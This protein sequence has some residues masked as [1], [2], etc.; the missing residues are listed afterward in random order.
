MDEVQTM[1]DLMLQFNN[2]Y[3]AWLTQNIK[4]AFGYH[5]MSIFFSYILADKHTYQNG[6]YS[7]D[8][9]NNSPQI[10]MLLYL[11]SISFYHN[12]IFLCG[13]WL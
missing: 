4:Q 9:R 2:L 8:N 7:D 1:A 6:L 12:I 13:F 5:K 3:N 11:L 10:D